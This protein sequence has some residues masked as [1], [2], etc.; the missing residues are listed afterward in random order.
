MY[1]SGGTGRYNMTGIR[2][3]REDFR[4]WDRFL[5]SQKASTVYH[6][7][8]WLSIIKEA[9]GHEPCCILLEDKDGKFV[10]GLPLV[11]VR[12]QLT[13]TRLTSVPGG[14]SCNPLVRN[15]D[16]YDLL[17]AYLFELKK[18]RGFKYIE[19]RTTDDFGFTHH[20]LVEQGMGLS[21]YSL[22]LSAPLDNVFSSFHHSCV[23]RA[24]K[25]SAKA[26]LALAVGGAETDVMEFYKLYCN[27]RKQYGLF[28]QPYIFFS[29]MWSI[30]APHGKIE[31]LSA[32]HE[33]QTISSVLLLKH[34]DTVT[35]EYGASLDETLH[36]H[37]SHF[38]L[39]EAI[40]RAKAEGYREFSFGRTFDTN[41]S[42]AQFKTRWG[43]T[44]KRLC[45]Y[46]ITDSSGTRSFRTN[47]TLQR[48]MS[49][50]VRTSP[51]ILNRAF[52]RLL[53]AHL[54]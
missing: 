9:Y 41:T 11:N 31:I 29:K 20:G 43:T 51:D 16:D 19:L 25:K 5:L 40:R 52:A 22:D 14:E 46:H 13:G 49:W 32:S 6:T 34:G 27:M 44:R 42:L 1:D 28:P 50:S 53:Y 2:V 35:Y 7:S 48:L 8:Q 12:S 36:L 30:L 26:G 45:Y 18:E 33:G 15:Q 39:W 10:G 4:D 17:L 54:V 24:I 21:T 23:Q 47:S 3:L 37:P 38:L